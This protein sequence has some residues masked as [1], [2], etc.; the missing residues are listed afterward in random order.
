[1]VEVRLVLAPTANRALTH[2]A[3]PVYSV[4]KATQEELVGL[5][6]D[7]R[8]PETAAAHA[9]VGRPRKTRAAA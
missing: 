3:T 2:V 8:K 7:G 4:K 9:R 5:L 1:V 6:L